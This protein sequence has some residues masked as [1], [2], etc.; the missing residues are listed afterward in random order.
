MV[1]TDSTDLGRNPLECR[2]WMELESIPPA[3]SRCTLAHEESEFMMTHWV[4]HWG[5]PTVTTLRYGPLGQ[6]TERGKVSALVDS[7]DGGM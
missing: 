3:R 6:A 2:E 5:S 7:D 4:G 1:L